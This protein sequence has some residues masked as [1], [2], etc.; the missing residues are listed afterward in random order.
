MEPALRIMVIKLLE[1]I[2]A[3]KETADKLQIAD[4]SGYRKEGGNHEDISKEY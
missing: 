3:D 2:D 4:V 1:K